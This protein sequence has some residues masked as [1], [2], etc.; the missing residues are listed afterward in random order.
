MHTQRFQR[1]VSL[2]KSETIV[3]LDSLRNYDGTKCY[4]KKPPLLMK[5]IAFS[6]SLLCNTREKYK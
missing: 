1:T 4:S 6:S 2:T 5:H 3:P